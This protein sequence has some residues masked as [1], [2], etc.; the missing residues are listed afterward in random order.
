M[1][2]VFLLTPAGCFLAVLVL[3]GVQD[4][5]VAVET[6]GALSAVVL[7]V[8][9]VFSGALGRFWAFIG[10]AVLVVLLLISEVWEV[11][12]WWG[13]PWRACGINCVTSPSPWS[14]GVPA[15]AYMLVLFALG[16][17]FVYLAIRARQRRV[18][19][20]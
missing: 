12:H 20:R 18:T 11:V 13:V 14:Q 1:K 15:L 10:A 19:T 9:V 4:G 17:I 7:V 3:V 2:W 8:G 6:V 5:A 16:A